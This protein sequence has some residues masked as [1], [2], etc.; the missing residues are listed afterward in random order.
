MFFFLK[1][2]HFTRNPPFIGHGGKG[3]TQ[4]KYT[5]LIKLHV[6]SPANPSTRALSEE[7]LEISSLQ[8]QFFP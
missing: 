4:S 7:L 1:I 3:S 5:S 8:C 6:Q 2:D